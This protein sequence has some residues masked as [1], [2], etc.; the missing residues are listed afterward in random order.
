MKVVLDTNVLLVSFSTKSSYRWV[1]DAFLNEEIT[2]CVTTDILVEYEEIIGRHMGEKIANTLMQ[3]IE[4]AP[5]VEYVTRYF[6]W[7]LISQDPDDNKFVDCA[8]SSNANYLITN[9]KHFEILKKINF[10]K[11]NLLKVEEFKKKLFPE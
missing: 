11:V 7:N 2:L 1:F 5:N 8:V 3:I 6:K 10:P 9:D 4:N